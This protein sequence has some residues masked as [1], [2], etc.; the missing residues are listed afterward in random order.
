LN[1]SVLTAKSP[2]D[3]SVVSAVIEPLTVTEF[4]ASLT[5]SASVVGPIS[6]VVNRTDSTSTN[7]CVLVIASP[8]VAPPVPVCVIVAAFADSDTAPV[9][10]AAPF[11][12]DAALT[13]SAPDSVAEVAVV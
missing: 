2:V 3:E 1:L 4:N 8:F 5:R 9:T 11:R 12:V 7:P 13:V 6:S 10:V